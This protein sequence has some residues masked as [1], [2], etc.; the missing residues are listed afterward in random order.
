MEKSGIVIPV[1]YHIFK[2]RHHEFRRETVE[3]VKHFV[4]RYRVT[5][6]EIVRKNLRKSFFTSARVNS[7]VVLGFL[8]F[9]G[10]FR[11]KYA[12]YFRAYLWRFR[13]S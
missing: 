2:V 7:G 11:T 12:D 13:P 9:A 1:I 8:G 3:V 4:S 10:A 6:V 5:F